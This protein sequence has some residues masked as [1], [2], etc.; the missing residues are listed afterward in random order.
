MS[1]LSEIKGLIYGNLWLIFKSK[2]GKKKDTLS[3]KVVWITGASSCIGEHIAYQLAA[4]G[5][6]LVLSSRRK[7]ELER[8]KQG[9]ILS[10]R[11]NISEEDVLVLPLD[12]VKFESHKAAVQKV[13]EYFNKVDILINN[14]GKFQQGWWTDVDLNVDREIFELDVLG[15][16][17]LTQ[18]VLPH[19]MERKEGHIVV[20][21]SLAGILGAPA[22]RA[23]CGSKH[24]LHGYFDC[25]RFEM[26]DHNIDVTLICPGPVVSNIMTSAVGSKER[27]SLGPDSDIFKEK[28]STERCA[29]L[30]CVAIANRMYE[31][32]ITQQPILL[33]TY[34]LIYLPDFG[35]WIS[36]KHGVK[37]YL[38]LKD[39]K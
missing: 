35:K 1:K 36:I 8:V 19:M 29:Y 38:K 20:M 9:C 12:V 6:K 24:A 15:P 28:M 33:M 30:S 2:W 26:A 7:E 17:S 31:V 13:L 39:K 10:N 3:G 25:L 5:C 21:S 4:A 23:Y 34:I 18:A 22:S 14:A 32:W 37:R 11:K 16:V 27:E